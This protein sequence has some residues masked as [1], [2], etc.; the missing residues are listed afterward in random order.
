MAQGMCKESIYQRQ[1][2]R[3]NVDRADFYHI[4]IGQTT[5][6]R[7]WGLIK[8]KEAEHEVF[9]LFCFMASIDARHS[10]TTF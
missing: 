10:S 3:N 6:L 4:K 9:R 5:L 8:T 1:R 7:C 2:K